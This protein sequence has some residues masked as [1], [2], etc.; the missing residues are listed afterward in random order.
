MNNQQ[1]IHPE[2]Q[3]DFRPEMPESHHLPTWI[4]I[5]TIAIIGLLV[6][7][8][9]VYGAYQYILKPEPVGGKSSLPSNLLINVRNS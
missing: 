8:L 1:E 9:V 5:T 6:I 4:W 3:P 7:G 2:L